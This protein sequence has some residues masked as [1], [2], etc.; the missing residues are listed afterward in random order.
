MRDNAFLIPVPRH[1]T[2]YTECSCRPRSEQA[3]WD[4]KGNHV[5]VYG[6]YGVCSNDGRCG[7]CDVPKKRIS[8]FFDQAL[9]VVRVNPKN[10]GL[11]AFEHERDG[12]FCEGRQTSWE[13]LSEMKGVSFTPFDDSHGHGIRVARLQDGLPEGWRPDK[14]GTEVDYATPS[15]ITRARQQYAEGSNDEIEVDDNA[16]ASRGS[17]GTWVQVWV[18]IGS[19][20]DEEDDSEL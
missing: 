12:W 20:E 17:G 13:E 7:S 2:G 6:H 18:W 14:E 19:D 16:R 11:V 10:G 15:E 9:F 5:P 1:D 3:F 4:L 8:P